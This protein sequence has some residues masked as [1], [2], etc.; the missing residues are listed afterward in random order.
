MGERY[1][2][3][4]K[5]SESSSKLNYEEVYRLKELF[6]TYYKDE[7][8]ELYLISEE[9]Y[10]E[11]LNTLNLLELELEGLLESYNKEIENLTLK[12]DTYKK[13]FDLEEEVSIREL[14]ELS[15]D[16]DRLYNMINTAEKLL[17]YLANIKLKRYKKVP[18][19][20]FK[21]VKLLGGK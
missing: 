10:K 19:R 6:N 1:R 15:A 9:V 21:F 13:E 11:I 8:K 4:L 20:L 5:D 16:R 18:Y 3:K 12:L 17:D 2:I 7:D 14:K